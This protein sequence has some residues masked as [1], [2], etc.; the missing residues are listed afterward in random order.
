MADLR[1][2]LPVI[3]IFY[4]D[5]TEGFA[6]TVGFTRNLTIWDST[7]VVFIQSPTTKDATV[8]EFTLDFTVA[9][10]IRTPAAIRD[11]IGADFTRGMT[12]KN[13]AV[14]WSGGLTF[15]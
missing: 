7:L 12:S 11:F 4:A 5:F 10:C 14:I 1:I 6:T 2:E 15:C 8:V 13:S 3:S 9:G